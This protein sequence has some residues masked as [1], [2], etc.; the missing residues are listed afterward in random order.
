MKIRSQQLIQDLQF[1]STL[2]SKP[3]T[4]FEYLKHGKYG[5]NTIV[6]RFGFW[7]NALITAIGE[8]NL[9]LQGI[10]NI[11]CSHCHA[12]LTIHKSAEKTNNFCSQS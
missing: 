4:K 10:I 2:I 12:P 3:P 7:N 5:V 1:V 8:T 11:E 9:I 6:R